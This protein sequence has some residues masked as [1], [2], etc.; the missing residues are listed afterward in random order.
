MA[1]TEQHV[2]LVL[3]AVRRAPELRAVPPTK[4][5]E[6]QQPAPKEHHSVNTV[7]NGYHVGGNG[8]TRFRNGRRAQQLRSRDVSGKV[9]EAKQIGS[10]TGK[11]PKRVVTIA[12]KQFFAVTGRPRFHTQG[13]R[14]APYPFGNE[15]PDRFGFAR[16]LALELDGPPAVM[17]DVGRSE[18]RRVGA[19]VRHETSQSD[20]QLVQIA[21]ARG[22]LRLP[23]GPRNRRQ[24]QCREQSNNSDDDQEFYQV[25]RSFSASHSKL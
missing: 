22:L 18:H 24:Q 10:P 25:K 16:D 17:S 5:V 21:G 20:T 15:V 6:L 12:A 8:Y 11:D 3:M 1:V 23:F 13:R 7:P 19:V 9:V 4:L 2:Y 14:A